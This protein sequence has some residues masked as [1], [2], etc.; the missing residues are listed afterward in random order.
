[1]DIQIRCGQKA[2]LQAIKSL[3]IAC[4]EGVSLEQD[5]ERSLGVLNGRDWRWRKMRHI[6][7]DVAAHAE[8]LFVAVCDTTLVGYVS[9][10]I[11]AEAGKGR[12]VNLAVDPQ[13]QGAGLGRRLIEFALDYF[14]AAGLSYA[15]IETMAQNPIGQHLYPACGFQEVA[16]QVHYAQRL[17]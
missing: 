12:I 4:F 8:G 7:D 3:T 2:D 11:D 10:R 6:D 14:R 1:M 5:V 17:D 13:H 15:V 9:T 16:R